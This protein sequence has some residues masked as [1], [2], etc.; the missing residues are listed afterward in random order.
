MVESTDI[1]ADDSTQFSGDQSHMSGAGA[2]GLDE[3]TDVVEIPRDDALREQ[4]QEMVMNI[5][6]FVLTISQKS[7]P[8][9]VH[10]MMAIN[11][12]NMAVSLLA[13]SSVQVPWKFDAISESGADGGLVATGVEQ[14][15]IKKENSFLLSFLRHTFDVYLLV[16]GVSALLFCASFLVYMSYDRTWTH[17]EVEELTSGLMRN[18]F[19]Y[20]RVK[21]QITDPGQENLI[22]LVDKL[23]GPKNW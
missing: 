22:N 4:T 10:E 7:S 6:N 21:S 17:K 18:S 13:L 5:K 14:Q 19:H 16:C 11:Q 23:L 15:G 20:Y 12:L 3:S 8:V 9:S 2:H 1:F